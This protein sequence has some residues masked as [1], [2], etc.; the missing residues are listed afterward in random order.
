MSAWEP[1]A[2][3]TITDRGV[4]MRYRKGEFGLYD[5]RMPSVFG[6][7]CL[8]YVVGFLSGVGAAI[9]FY[10]TPDS[11]VNWYSLGG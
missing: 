6:R 11:G 10:D 7:L 8:A 5:C 2:G 3:E 4:F 1:G 9:F